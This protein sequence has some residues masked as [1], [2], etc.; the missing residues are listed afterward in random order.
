MVVTFLPIV[1]KKHLFG[2]VYLLDVYQTIYQSLNCLDRRRLNKQLLE[3]KE[4]YDGLISG[5]SWGRHPAAKMWSSYTELL[6]HY[7]NICRD[8]LLQLN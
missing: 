8:I 6:A 5:T 1:V 3:A 7:H 2:N 4:I